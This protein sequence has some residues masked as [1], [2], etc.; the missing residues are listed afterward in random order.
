MAGRPVVLPEGISLGSAAPPATQA[1]LHPQGLA[2]RI[3]AGLAA[4]PPLPPEAAQAVRRA[5]LELPDALPAPIMA[6]TPAATP[7]LVSVCLTHYRR[8]ALLVQAVE[9][10]LAQDYP[11]LEAVLVDDGSGT[12]EAEACLDR[13]APLFAARGWALVRQDNHYLGAARNAAAAAARGDWLLFLDDDNRLKPHAVSR[14]IA[15]ATALQA[16]IVTC[17]A[18]DYAGTAPPEDGR[19]LGRYLPVGAVAALGMVRNCFG[20]AN[21]LV[22]RRCLTAVGGFTEDRGVGHEDWELFA[23]AVLAGFRLE[24]VP[25]ALYWY[26][27]GG[28]GGAMLGSTSPAANQRRSLR[29]FLEQLD[30]R[31][32]PLLLALKTHELMRRDQET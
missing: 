32:Q 12:A 13:L 3:A 19:P 25:E 27:I 15:A 8:P 16:D 14:F 29:P 11:A 7:P 9:S 22:S 24:V 17:F 1:P 23:R 28:D 6:A 20:D 30:P 5:W 18:D 31:L 4:P 26:R 2:R 10:V 21:A